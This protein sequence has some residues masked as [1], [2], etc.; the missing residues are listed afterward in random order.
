MK[1][2]ALVGLAL[3]TIAGTATAEP[4]T[5]NGI[6]FPQGAASFAD[7]VSS[8]APGPDVGGTYANPAAAL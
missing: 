4:I 1:Q 2:L 6:T 7:V 3:L 8:Y 5:I